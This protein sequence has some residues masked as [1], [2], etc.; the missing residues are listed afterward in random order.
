LTVVAPTSLRHRSR[1]QA[2]AIAAIKRDLEGENGPF[3]PKGE[4][5]CTLVHGVDAL[6]ERQLAE[7][8]GLSDVD[9][10]AAKL[11]VAAAHPFL[12]ERPGLD[13]TLSQVTGSSL[14]FES[15][16][17]FDPRRYAIRVPRWV[18]DRMTRPETTGGASTRALDDAR[19]R[20]VRGPH[21]SI[22]NLDPQTG[23]LQTL[24]E[25]AH[26]VRAG[27]QVDLRAESVRLMLETFPRSTHLPKSVR[28]NM[29]RV[30]EYA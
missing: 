18:A 6:R 21:A 23:A 29:Y 13:L 12:F 5:T 25:L 14:M 20:I 24:S 11:V 22:H 16:H 15:T 19:R 1:V 26:R 7:D 9:V 17:R 28:A 8:A 10:E 4:W 30:A 27:E 3:H 2:E